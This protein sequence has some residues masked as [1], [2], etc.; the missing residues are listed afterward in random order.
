MRDFC[1]GAYRPG[2]RARRQGDRRLGRRRCLRPRWR[3]IARII[4][5]GSEAKF[6]VDSLLEGGGFEPSVPVEDSIFSRPPRKPAT[7][8][9]AG[10][11]NRVLTITRAGFTV[12][13]AG[14]ASNAGRPIHV[15]EQIL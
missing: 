11:Q 10:S 14:L 9:P 5:A 3:L 8:K 7:K 6:A 2:Q 1:S 13:R 15:L 12:R 4:H